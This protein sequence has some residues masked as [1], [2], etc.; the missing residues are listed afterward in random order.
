MANSDADDEMTMADGGSPVRKKARVEDGNKSNCARCNKDL[1]GESPRKLSAISTGTS[2]LR[3]LRGGVVCAGCRHKMAD[4]AKGDKD[5]VCRTSVL[6]VV[7]YL[8]RNV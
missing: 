4:E 7:V 5:K 8:M 1:E 2:D 3:I 6:C